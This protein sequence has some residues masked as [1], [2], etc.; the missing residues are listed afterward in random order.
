MDQ[1]WSLT[2]LRMVVCMNPYAKIPL[3]RVIFQ[4]RYDEQCGLDEATPGRIR[5]LYAGEHIR[6]MEA[7]EASIKSPMQSIIEDSAR[8]R[9]GRATM[10]KQVD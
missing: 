5:R 6:Q 3:P 4:G 1:D 10:T 9:H 8:A 2:Q 7:Q